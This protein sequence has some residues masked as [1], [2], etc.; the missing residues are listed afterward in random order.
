MCSSAMA[1]WKAAEPMHVRHGICQSSRMGQ[2]RPAPWVS[3]T[4]QEGH[5]GRR[6]QAQSRLAGIVRLGAGHHSCCCHATPCVLRSARRH[7]IWEPVSSAARPS[8]VSAPSPRDATLMYCEGTV[9]MTPASWVLREHQQQQ[10]NHSLIPLLSQ[11]RLG[12]RSLT[13]ASNDNQASMDSP[14]GAAVAG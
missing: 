8:S 5:P 10:S 13:S 4:C 7:L 14:Y 9:K 12:G 6:T 3:V 2:A 11:M 1:F